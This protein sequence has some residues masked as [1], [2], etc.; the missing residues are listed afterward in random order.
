M[1][2]VKYLKLTVAVVL[3]LATFSSCTKEGADFFRGTYGYTMSGVLNCEYDVTTLQE[4]ED[5]SMEEVTEVRTADFQLVAGR[6]VMH[7]EPKGDGMVLTMSAVAGNTV[8]FDAKVNGTEITLSK[9]ACK[10]DV[11][12][13][14]EVVPVDV[15]VSASGYKTNGLLVLDMQ[16]AQGT[17]FSRTDV[18]GD[19]TQYMVKGGSA[20][21]VATLQE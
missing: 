2:L 10:L 3:S 7:L 8:V 19:E 20:S 21:C 15:T 17:S 12:V 18:W 9:T 5:G 11:L 16:F 1:S 4:A 14:G 6:G 13:N